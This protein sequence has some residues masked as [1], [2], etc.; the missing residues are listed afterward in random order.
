METLLEEVLKEIPNYSTGKIEMFI[1]LL[2]DLL[3][4]KPD[5]ED[6]KAV[7]RALHYERGVR[8]WSLVNS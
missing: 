6:V 2:E 8:I 4:Y 1:E 5:D 3:T 7:L